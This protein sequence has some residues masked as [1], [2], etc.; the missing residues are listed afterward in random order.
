MSRTPAAAAVYDT[1][2][3]GA[4]F[5][6]DLFNYIKVPRFL[7]E[8]KMSQLSEKLMEDFFGKLTERTLNK[9]LRIGD[10]SRRIDNC[11]FTYLLGHIVTREQDAVGVSFRQSEPAVEETYKYMADEIEDDQGILSILF[12]IRQE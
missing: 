3:S 10:M 11:T 4:A 2:P 5:V 1:M 7:D 9:N 8:I 12:D 6:I